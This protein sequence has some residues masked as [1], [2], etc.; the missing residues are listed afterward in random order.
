MGLSER[1]WGVSP[2]ARLN[3]LSVS[4]DYDCNP[5][6]QGSPHPLG[7]KCP[8]SLEKVFLDLPARSVKKVSKIP[9]TLILTPFDSFSGLLG[10][11]QHLFGTPGREA[12][13]DLLRLLG[14]SGP[15]GLVTLY[16]AVPIATLRK[17]FARTPLPSKE[18]PQILYVR[19]SF[20]FKI[21]EKG[22]T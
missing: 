13:E 12:W 7:P 11:F 19:G 8:K 18:P 4:I 5:H 21:Q 17:N 20:P 14:I 9:R 3:V 1:G 15:D 2:Q 10:P 22:L 16:M 6:I